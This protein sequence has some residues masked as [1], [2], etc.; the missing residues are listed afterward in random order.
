MSFARW[1]RVILIAALVPSVPSAFAQLSLRPVDQAAS[2]PEFFTF[3]AH[4]QA[5]IAGRDASAVLA[6]V[7]ERIKNSFGGDGGVEE[8]KQK[9]KL[10]ERDSALWKELGTVL[11]L[12]GSFDRD[13]RFIAPY[14][15]SR[16]PEK[17]NSFD[18]VAIIGTNVRVREAPRNDSTVV[19]SLNFAVMPLLKEQSGHEGWTAIRQRNGKTGYV[20]S[21]YA[22]SPIGYRAI[23]E[24]I[25]NRW[26]LTAFV[27]G[28]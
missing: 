15:F 4:L 7:H 18:N 24:R 26:Q 19:G 14:V 25:D 10:G 11:A 23:F 8:F 12:G 6:V 1:C 2:Q 27:A 5:A 3:R 21:Q 9:W 16:W 28:D 20:L 17:A 13:G 22:R